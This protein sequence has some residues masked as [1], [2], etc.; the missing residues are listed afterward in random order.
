MNPLPKEAID[1]PVSNKW[2]S[3]IEKEIHF[4]MNSQV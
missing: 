2:L 3:V 1:L 4:M